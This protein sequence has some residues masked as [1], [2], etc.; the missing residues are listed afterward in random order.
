MKNLLV[1]ALAS[2]VPALATAS[3]WDIDPAHSAAQFSVRHLMV[4]NIRGEFGKVTGTVNLDDKDITKSTVEATI[5][6]TSI[7]TRDEKRDGHLKS[8]DFFDVAKFPTV[9]F[10]ST[11]VE[12]A[13]KDKY[14]VHGDLTI[15]GVTKSV[16]LAVEGSAEQK[17]P[18]GNV[19]R[20]FAATTK[21]NRKD[22]GL[23]WNKALETGGVVVGEEIA[24]TLDIEAAKKVAA[25]AP[26]A[27]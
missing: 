6:A 22:F 18:W 5:D 26:A 20:G 3:E 10:K 23:A 7:I 17:D 13:G 4:S 15:H 16:V 11:K 1:F 8:P 24:I 25:P 14:K 21:I 9:T 2:F 19:K 27:K 12:K